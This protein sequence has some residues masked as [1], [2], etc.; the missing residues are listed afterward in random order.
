MGHGLGT[1]DIFRED[2]LP[3]P[4]APSETQICRSP[5]CIHEGGDVCA[6]VG[7][8]IWGRR[9]WICT[10][11]D[12]E[13]NYSLIQ[14]TFTGHIPLCVCPKVTHLGDFRC[15]VVLECSWFPPVLSCFSAFSDHLNIL[16]A[17]RKS[18]FA[19]GS[20]RPFLLLE[21]E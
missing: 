8:H 2:D 16:S 5:C 13:M 20:R 10:Q 17:S 9:C 19:S 15:R 7:A 3:L 6:C 21:T 14:P 1:P 12:G 4:G 18:T 11:C